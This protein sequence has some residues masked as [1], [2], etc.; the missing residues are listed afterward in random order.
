MSG[1]EILLAAALLVAPPESPLPS[2]PAEDFPAFRIAVHRLAV[3]WEI[4]DVR[5]MKNFLPR[6]QDLESDLNLLRRRYQ[7]LKDAPHIS[8]SRRFPERAII[9]EMLVFNR[10]FRKHLDDRQLLETDR[11]AFY[12]AAVSETDRLYQIWDAVR[13]S[14]CELFYITSRRQALKRLRSLIGQEAYYAGELPPHV[15]VWRF[16][17]IN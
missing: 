2:I 8:D 7:D 1:T 10:G 17:E 16:Q 15:P 3:E 5:E 6:P 12:R 4:L 11:A 13:D 14:R 9:N